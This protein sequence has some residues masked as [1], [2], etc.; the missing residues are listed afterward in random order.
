VSTPAHGGVSRY[1]LITQPDDGVEAV[2]ALLAS[3][4]KSLRVK[5]FTLDEHRILEALIHAHKKGVHVRVMLNQH[6]ASGHRFND[7]TYAKLRVAGV[8]VA[9]ANPHFVISHEKSVLI[10]GE[11][12]LI[13][14]FNMQ[15]KYFSHTRDY[16]IV[17]RD[18]A[19]V[20]EIER[21]FEADWKRET[22]HPDVGS[23]LAWSADNARPTM[24][25]L[26]DSAQHRLDIQHPK[27]IDSTILDRIAEAQDRG[28]HVRL[29]SGG[30]H[31]ISGADAPDTF[32]SLRILRRAGVKVRRQKHLKLHA[33]MMVADER[34][35][36]VG[37]MNIDHRS[38]DVRRELG[39][40]L[41]DKPIVDRLAAVFEH[42]WRQAED[43]L[44]PDPL[45]LASHDHGE[46]PDD[47]DFIHD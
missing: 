47:P 25:E 14:T 37:S 13:A 17:C 15:K 5:Q 46:L 41:G 45:Q 44:P 10:D 16:G 22:F 32:S 34:R 8:K 2:L 26:I 6:R 3:A 28:V 30:K 18:P 1:D 24:A 20:A 19:Q 9:W 35:A 39:I 27:F 4:S 11:V 33:K 38:F 31:G 7:D 43:Y 29:L 12:A 21:C 40:V 42:D 36:L 23:G